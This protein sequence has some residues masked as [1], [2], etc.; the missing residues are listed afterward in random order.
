[1]KKYQ[2]PDAQAKVYLLLMASL[3]YNSDRR[4]TRALNHLNRLLKVQTYNHVHWIIALRNIVSILLFLVPIFTRPPISENSGI[5][6]SWVWCLRGW[7]G[8][9]HHAGQF[10]QPGEPGGEGAQHQSL[11]L[12]NR[13]Q[14]VIAKERRNTPSHRFR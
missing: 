9:Y 13:N 8:I 10:R 3:Y 14:G 1:M 11:N 12:K 6:G 2:K 7:F 5:R 4:T